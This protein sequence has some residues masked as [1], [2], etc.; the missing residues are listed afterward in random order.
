MLVIDGGPPSLKATES[1]YLQIYSRPWKGGKEG[2]GRN[3]STLGKHTTR[4]ESRRRGTVDEFAFDCQQLTPCDDSRSP[5][6]A[7]SNTTS[8]VCVC[9]YKKEDCSIVKLFRDRCPH[10]ASPDNLLA[11]SVEEATRL[12]TVFGDRRVLGELVLRPCPGPDKTCLSTS[13]CLPDGQTGKP[14]P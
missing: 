11:V 10:A 3:K 13:R 1:Y 12:W 14:K 2:C 6:Q 7:R 8:R 4:D 5:R 9:L